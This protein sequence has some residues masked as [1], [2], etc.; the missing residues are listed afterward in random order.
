MEKE[1]Q[2]Q[3]TPSVDEEERKNDRGVGGREERERRPDGPLALS[4]TVA[5]GPETNLDQEPRERREKKRTEP[6]YH[7]SPPPLLARV[8]FF[9]P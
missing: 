3:S 4:Q 1:R 7:C 9:T 2:R 5:T 8:S 6:P